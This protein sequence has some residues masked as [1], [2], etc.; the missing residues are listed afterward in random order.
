MIS[1]MQH[2]VELAFHLLC[3]HGKCLWM[4]GSHDP[5]NLLAVQHDLKYHYTAAGR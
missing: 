1:N 5:I 4:I 2:V 3:L